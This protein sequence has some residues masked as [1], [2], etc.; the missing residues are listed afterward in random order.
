[1]N[2]CFIIN[3]TGILGGRLEYEYGEVYVIYF[4]VRFC[5]L[6]C[7]LVKHPFII[8]RWAL[9]YAFKQV[10]WLCLHCFRDWIQSRGKMGHLLLKIDKEELIYTFGSHPL[11]IR[12]PSGFLVAFFFLIV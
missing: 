11:P 5:T 8:Q 2:K 1:M 10:I 6:R 3:T 9:S 12:N 4:T 7:A